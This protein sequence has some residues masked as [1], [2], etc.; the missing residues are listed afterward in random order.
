MLTAVKSLVALGQAARLVFNRE[1]SASGS[2]V[3]HRV[4]S[5]LQDL[6]CT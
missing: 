4:E 3:R 1:A 2:A 6:F 5:R